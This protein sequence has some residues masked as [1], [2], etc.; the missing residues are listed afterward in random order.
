M[1]VWGVKQAVTWGHMTATEAAAA[2]LLYEG[3]DALDD[4]ILGQNREDDEGE[5]GNVEHEGDDAEHVVLELVLLRYV[6]AG[7]RCRGL[8]V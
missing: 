3:N 8:D 7:L 4:A 2:H 6:D 1:K 5:G